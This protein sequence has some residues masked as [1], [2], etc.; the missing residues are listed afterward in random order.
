MAA[1]ELR[2]TAASVLFKKTASICTALSFVAAAVFLVAVLWLPANAASSSS[3]VDTQPSFLLTLDKPQTPAPK[4][5]PA[6]LPSLTDAEREMLE[7]RSPDLAT[8]LNS[9]TYTQ[10]PL[11]GLFTN[12]VLQQFFFTNAMHLLYVEVSWFK[13]FA[14][15]DQSIYQSMGLPAPGFLTSVIN[16][17]T[18][19]QNTL[20][21]YQ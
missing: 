8:E 12:F 13:A 4:L 14:L 1:S 6:R 17:L 10:S 9:W 19:I 11:G 18:S 3:A 7:A 21:P 15:F 16:D 5:N 2:R 20:S